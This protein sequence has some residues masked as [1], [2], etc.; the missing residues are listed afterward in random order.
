M[1]GGLIEQNLARDP[2]RRRL[3]VPGVIT[4]VAPDA[5][6]AV[7]LRLGRDRVLVSDGAADDATLRITAISERLLALTA[8]PLRFGLPDVITPEGRAIVRDLLAGRIRIRGLFAH[9][10][11]LARISL[12]LSVR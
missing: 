12:L 2:E 7:T 5:G 4:I 8:A 10:R 1:L 3:L 11:R 6:V 9:P